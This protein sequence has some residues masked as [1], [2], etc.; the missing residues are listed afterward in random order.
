MS[1]AEAVRACLRRYA[2]FSG[3][4]QRP[5]FWWFTLFTILVGIGLGVLDALVFGFG[6]EGGR[7]LS[8]LASLAL[9]LPGLAVSVR[10]LHDVGRSGWW[11]LI[12]LV[13]LIGALVLLWWHTRPSEPGPNA[14]GP[15]PLP[16]P[17]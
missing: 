6:E 13:P 5:E 17:A 2:T 10:R 11:L 14:H 4:A 9:L 7:P 3:R 16:A 1:F 12:H 8:L 15:P